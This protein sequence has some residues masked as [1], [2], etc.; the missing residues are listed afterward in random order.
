MSKLLKALVVSLL[1][2]TVS[3]GSAVGLGYRKLT[4]Y[5]D[6]ASSEDPKAPVQRVD[7]PRGSTA[8]AIS[9]LLE[10]EGLIRNARQFYW[11]VRF[12]R[13]ADTQLRPGEY[14][15]SPGQT[16]AQLVNKLIKGDV[17]TYRFTIPEG[18]NLKDIGRIIGQSGLVPEE[19]LKALMWN[20]EFARSLEI[21]DAQDHLEGY[22][23]PDTYRFPKGVTARDLLK[24]LRQRAAKALTPEVVAAGAARNLTPHQILTLAS[25]VEKETGA[26]KE[27]PQISAV[28]HNRLQKGW[29]LQ[30]DPTVIYGIPDYAG[31]ITRKDLET[32]H[33]YNTYVIPGLPPG[34]IA[35]PGTAAIEAAVNPADVKSM[36][37]VSQNN[38]THIFCETLRCH[39]DNVRKWQVEFFR[40]EPKK[41]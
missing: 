29:K 27:R 5:A 24:H 21:P 20:R 2:M 15:L 7:I 3:V 22:L 34:P 11:Y 19:E 25:I 14:D 8:S 26:P 10:Q 18:S 9:T 32:P 33:P 37:F 23:F 16:P 6:R 4:A 30:T 28:F 38:G 31:N 41:G 40:K 12:I 35:A 13:Q 1:L 39:E 17:V 36:F